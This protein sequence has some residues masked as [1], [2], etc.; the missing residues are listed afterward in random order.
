[1]IRDK[2]RLF[3]PDL[4]AHNQEYRN[5]RRLDGIEDDIIDFGFRFSGESSDVNV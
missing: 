4:N 3:H 1:M 5:Y 2:L